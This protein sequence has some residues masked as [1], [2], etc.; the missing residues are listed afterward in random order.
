MV[1]YLKVDKDFE[2]IEALRSGKGIKIQGKKFR[3][4]TGCHSKFLAEEQVK[5]CEKMGH[6]VKVVCSKS[7]HVCIPEELEHELKGT[8]TKLA[9]AMKHAEKAIGKSVKTVNQAS[10]EILRRNEAGQD[11][12]RKILGWK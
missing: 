1:D 5:R 7:Y 10:G 12:V 11:A 8:G 4:V 9:T 2:E 6:K 3:A